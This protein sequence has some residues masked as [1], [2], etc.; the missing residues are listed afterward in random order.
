VIVAL[1]A[2][3]IVDPGVLL[4]EALPGVEL[5]RNDSGRPLTRAAL[6]ELVAGV[7]AVLSFGGDR[8]DAEFF[9]AA[10]PALR[11]VANTA[12]GVDN[13]DLTEA[14]RRG[15]LVTNTPDPV[16]EPT[17]DTAWLLL[18][19]A[20]RRLTEGSELVRS[21]EWK[22]FSPTLLL[23]H[24]VVGGTLLI[25]GAGRIGS[26]VARRA[27]GWDMEV[28]YVAR[29]SKPVLESSPVSATR[30]ELDEGL[31]R[32][33]FVV[34]SV[35]LASETRHLIDARRLSLMKPTAVLVNVARGPV[36]DEA[37]LVRALEARQIFAAGLDVFENEP[38][39]HPGLLALPNAVLLPHLG[40]ATFEDRRDVI[41][42]GVANIV[43]V[44][45]G[46]APPNR[47]G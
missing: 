22:G 16:R 30:V 28:L 36:V 43:A 6:L 44:L 3:Y 17:A 19:A 47:A 29:S 26:A 21:G 9:E 42:M 25:V 5:R 33:D 14:R 12:V 46:Q 24:R 34:I 8:I 10:G 7:D 37:A 15:V 4:A 45:R 27:L 23:G 38:E 40:S 1:T 13:I 32:A 41:A 11:V 18:L 31:A 39:V 20:A 2:E 35:P